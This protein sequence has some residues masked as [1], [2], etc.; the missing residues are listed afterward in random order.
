MNNLYNEVLN[1]AD[2]F[3]YDLACAKYSES[4]SVFVQTV[5]KNIMQFP[6]IKGMDHR[7]SF[8][9]SRKT[10]Q[11]WAMVTY[12]PFAF[13]LPEHPEKHNGFKNRN[14]VI[15]KIIKLFGISKPKNYE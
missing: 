5:R 15:N 4:Y 14:E 7:C 13:D 11:L 10:R 8:D 2:D 6:I 9:I 12:E 1:W 3:E